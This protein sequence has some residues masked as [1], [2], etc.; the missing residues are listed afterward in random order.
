M[1]ARRVAP[2]QATYLGYPNTTGLR[3]I[4]YRIT[5]AQLD[6]PGPGDA[7]HTEALVRLPRV[8]FT[9]LVVAGIPDPAPPPALHA[10]DGRVPFA[11]FTNFVKVRPPMLR[12]WATLLGRVAN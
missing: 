3:A 8:F 9:Q 2:V 5:D 7:L 1:L 4:D 12:L 6:P 11:V 10:P